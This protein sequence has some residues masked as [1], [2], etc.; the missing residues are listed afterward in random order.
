M[1]FNMSIASSSNNHSRRF[2]WDD[3]LEEFLLFGASDLRK[4]LEASSSSEAISS[5]DDCSRASRI[6]KLKILKEKADELDQKFHEEMKDKVSLKSQLVDRINTCEKVL[7]FIEQ[8]NITQKTSDYIALKLKVELLVLANAMK[9]LGRFHSVEE[10]PNIILN[11]RSRLPPAIFRNMKMYYLLNDTISEVKST[12]LKKFLHSFELHLSEEGGSWGAVQAEGEGTEGRAA[13]AVFLKQAHSWLLSYTLVSILPFAIMESKQA[14]LEAFQRAIDDAF[15]PL[16]GRFYHHLKQ[17]REAKSAHQM[18]W[19]F[20][21]A[22]NFVS[23]L[24]SLCS[25]ITSTDQLGQLCALDY[26]TAGK[27]QIVDKALKFLRAHVA[28]VIAEAGSCSED[29]AA[30]LLE[31]SLELDHWLASSHQATSVLP[32]TLCAVLYDAKSWFHRLLWT[33]QRTVFQHLCEHCSSPAA[34][35]HDMFARRASSSAGDE[36]HLV[37][38][39]S[40][41][42]GQALLCYHSLYHC[43]MMLQV[44]RQRYARFPP[45][46]QQIFAEVL[47]EPMLCLSV[48]LLLYRIRS[49]RV[50]FFVS[51][52]MKSRVADDRLCQEHLEQFSKVVAYFQTALSA[53]EEAASSVAACSSRCKRRWHIVQSWMPKIL[54]TETQSRLGFSLIDLLKTALK[55]SDRFQ[56]AKFEYRTVQQDGE[57][58]KD[59]LQLARGLAITLVDVLKQQILL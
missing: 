46:A 34:A 32:L 37:P 56:S 36:H 42:Q 14:V 58:L 24:L 57:S 40:S 54:I 2:S 4:L 13:W 30:R 38:S 41:S 48:G 19:T 47:L 53:V 22:R 6:E 3:Q 49:D 39:F 23:M 15:T 50:L 51:M 12:L 29:F 55:T 16:W 44:C 43:L 52:G 10:I 20:S 17:G 11:I 18:F 26:A 31:E 28:Q 33:E 27:E 1:S 35:F 21:F 9:D 25:Y 59:C 8:H 45:A 5:E 7:Q